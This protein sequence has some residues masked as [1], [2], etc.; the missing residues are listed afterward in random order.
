MH[1]LYRV[2][3]ET[4]SAAVGY[5]YVPVSAAYAGSTDST[6][7]DAGSSNWHWV[8]I[9]YVGLDAHSTGCVSTRL[10]PLLVNLRDLLLVFL[11]L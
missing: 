8:S 2:N 11:L 5:Y 3:G 6:G 7:R 1:L 9:C 4:V 10:A